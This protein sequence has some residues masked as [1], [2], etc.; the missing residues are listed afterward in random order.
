MTEKITME[1]N[2]ERVHAIQEIRKLEPKNGDII[3]VRFLTNLPRGPVD[4]LM[5]TL[6]E[7]KMRHKLDLLILTGQGEVDLSKLSEE[8]MFKAGWVK[9]KEQKKCVECK[10]EAV[11]ASLFPCGHHQQDV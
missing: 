6:V 10:Q 2:K 4:L 7:W 11:P 8:K 9:K 5:R 3:L 1:G